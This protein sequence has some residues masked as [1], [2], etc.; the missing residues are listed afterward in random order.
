MKGRPS[1]RIVTPGYISS[2]P[3]VVKEADALQEAGYEVSVVFAQGGL[4][5]LREFD[6]ELLAGK[7]WRWSAIDGS[8]TGARWRNR[9]ARRAP[10]ILLGL[11]SIAAVAESAVYPDLASAAASEMADLYIGHYPAGLAAAVEAAGRWG[12]RA[13]Y[14]AEDLHSGEGGDRRRIRRVRAIERRC[15]RRCAQV[16]ASSPRIAAELERRYGIEPPVVIHNV[17]PWS[18][19]RRMDG[20]R[21]DRRGPELSIYWYSQTVGLDR[22]LQDAI[23]A[24]G[25]LPVQLHVRGALSEEVR[26]ELFRLAA[27]HGAESKLFFHQ[28]VAPSELLSRAAEHDVGLAL[29]HPVDVNKPMAASNKLFLYLLAGLAV[30]A[31]DVE[32]QAAVLR[33]SPGAG[34]L[35]PPGDSAKLALLLSRWI[36]R[37]DELAQSRRS[38]LDAARTRWN[39]E[40]ESRA[41]ISLARR[42]LD[43]EAGA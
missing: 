40:S 10:S 2:T 43:R 28:P 1:V 29:E 22:G 39:W 17:F 38:A 20:R 41:L 15:L 36:E 27:E 32:G 3:R 33:A 13:G 25:R 8:G 31:T 19:R 34:F 4:D 42:T 9:A 5:T 14:D 24:A 16:T 26:V 6:S 18:D 11:G 37:P 35:Y 30:A 23:R 21:Q 12:A 7:P